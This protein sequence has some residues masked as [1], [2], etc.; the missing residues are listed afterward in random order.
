MASLLNLWLQLGQTYCVVGANGKI[1]RW[2]TFPRVLNLLCHLSEWKAGGVAAMLDNHLATEIS[3]GNSCQC[4]K[5]K[6][7][8]SSNLENS[9]NLAQNIHSC[10]VYPLPLHLN[11]KKWKQNPEPRPRVMFTWNPESEGGTL[12]GGLVMRVSRPAPGVCIQ[13]L[14]TVS[15]CLSFTWRWSPSFHLGEETLL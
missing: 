15:Q 12:R 9:M 7:P 3:K 4:L 11:L 10:S 14:S 1:L 6:F 13:I 5:P 2:N 8:D